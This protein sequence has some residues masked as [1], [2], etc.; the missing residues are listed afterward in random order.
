MALK[1]KLERRRRAD[2]K[3]QRLVNVGKIAEQ[4]NSQDLRTRLNAI[5][6]WAEEAK[7]NPGDM[8]VLK[9]LPD[10]VRHLKDTNTQVLGAVLDA[11]K[12]AAKVNPG[13]DEVLKYLP[14]VSER[15]GDP[16]E[17]VR[18]AANS[19]WET[20]AKL[21]PEHPLIRKAQGP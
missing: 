8:E 2:E 12:T 9:Y 15:R 16:D 19:A 20:A 18:Y 7:Q 3:K 1:D 10:V 17:L 11:W 5:D 14:A 21:N 4:F 6:E 13:N